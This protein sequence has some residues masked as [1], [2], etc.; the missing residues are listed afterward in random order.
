M[1]AAF[2]SAI[3]DISCGS[4]ILSWIASPMRHDRGEREVAVGAGV[5][6]EEIGGRRI[7]VSN[8]LLRE[9]RFETVATGI[10]GIEQHR[11]TRRQMVRIAGCWTA[12]PGFR[13]PSLFTLPW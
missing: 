8:R 1:R 10:I 2:A 11:S 9:A 5:D 7:G 3:G 6:C 4:T 12:R 13:I